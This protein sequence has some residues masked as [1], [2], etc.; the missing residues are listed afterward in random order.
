MFNIRRID[1]IGFLKVWNSD[2]P[3]ESKH[4]VNISWPKRGF[5]H[6]GPC[7]YHNTSMVQN[8]CRKY[9]SFVVRVVFFSI[10]ILY[11]K[12]FVQILLV[13]ICMLIWRRKGNLIWYKVNSKYRFYEKKS[14]EMYGKCTG[15]LLLSFFFLQTA[16]LMISA[17]LKCQFLFFHA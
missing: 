2:S 11:S 15:S 7:L 4:G 3:Q 10:L 12:T 17:G 5:Y 8:C 16:L 13:V 6:I 9:F 14:K 1:L